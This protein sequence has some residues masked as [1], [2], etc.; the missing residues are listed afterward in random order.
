MSETK[1]FSIFKRKK[2]PFSGFYFQAKALS[3]FCTESRGLPM[4]F[5]PAGPADGARLLLARTVSVGILEIP[6]LGG[7]SGAGA[8][9]AVG[10]AVGFVACKRGRAALPAPGRVSLRVS[11][12]P[13]ESVCLWGRGGRWGPAPPQRFPPLLSCRISRGDAALPRSQHPLLGTLLVKVLG[14]L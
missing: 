3:R 1:C 9:L 12:P 10:S 7:V 13:P 4:A 11:S 5:P 14:R 8:G 2:N 6:I